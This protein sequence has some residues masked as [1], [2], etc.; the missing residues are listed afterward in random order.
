MW[1]LRLTLHFLADAGNMMDCACLAGI[2]ALKHF[3]RPEVE[4]IGDEVTV[5]RIPLFIPKKP[6]INWDVRYIFG[7]LVST[8]RAC[9]CASCDAPH[10][11][12]PNFRLS[13]PP[14]FTF[15]IILCFHFY[16]SERCQ[17]VFIFRI[18][19]YD[20]PPYS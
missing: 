16:I 5:V 11:H 6:L 13:H 7:I 3:R 14:S 10:A 9:T 17:P 18:I 19:C 4:V 1:H 20:S 12:M 15:I 8:S 2:V